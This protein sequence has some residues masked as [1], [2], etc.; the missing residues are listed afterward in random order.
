MRPCS[1]V[2]RSATKS[3]SALCRQHSSS[4]ATLSSSIRPTAWADLDA[5]RRSSPGLTQFRTPAHRREDRS[6]CSEKTPP[7][8][9]FGSADLSLAYEFMGT[10][11]GF[12]LSIAR[13]TFS[14][15]K[16]RLDACAVNTSS[17]IIGLGHPKPSEESRIHIPNSRF[18]R[19]RRRVG[20]P[21][22]VGL[23]YDDRAAA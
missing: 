21:V 15:T 6:R 18:H 23:Q 11:L 10:M 16:G 5:G 2:N 1:R 8:A 12:L 19:G 17:S 9:E 13:R 20:L 4:I 22:L 3:G 14:L 7:W